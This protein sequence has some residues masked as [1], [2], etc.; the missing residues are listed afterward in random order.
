[1]QINLTEALTSEHKAIERTVP[2]ELDTFVSQLGSFPVSRKEPVHL[3][4]ASLGGDRLRLTGTAELWILIPCDRCL[5][6]V[7][8]RFSLSFD[9]E[10][11]VRPAQ[12]AKGF[13]Q[14][15]S[16]SSLEEDEDTEWIFGYRLDVDELV[17]REIIANWPMKILGQEDCK[18]ICKRCGANL[19][20]GPCSCD[21][22]EQ[23]P[24]MAA[25][26]DIFNMRNEEV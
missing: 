21:T 8:T 16:E 10:I 1:M 23:D 25:I 15:S 26:R 3:M 17:C 11:R 13:C 22:V 6:D 9:R 18:G 2:L 19:N 4:L 7:E 5:A 24:R 12:E 14:E 20:R